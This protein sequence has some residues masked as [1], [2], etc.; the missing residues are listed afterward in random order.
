ME[1]CRELVLWLLHILVIQSCSVCLSRSC[2]SRPDGN[3]SQLGKRDPEHCCFLGEYKVGAVWNLNS[4]QGVWNFGYHILSGAST[5][6]AVSVAG[7]LTA[8]IGCIYLNSLHLRFAQRLLD[9]LS[10]GLLLMY[11][12]FNVIIF[13][14]AFYLRAHKQEVF[15]TNSVVGG[16]CHIHHFD[17]WTI[18]RGQRHRCDWLHRQPDWAGMGNLQIQEVP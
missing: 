1:N 15:F 14:E 18:L 12:I 4:P 16:G 2:R 3:D 6:F 11:M 5:T 9:P 10:L 7:A 13:A 17:L 8:L